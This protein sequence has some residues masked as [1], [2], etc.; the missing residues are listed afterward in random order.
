MTVEQ[1]MHVALVEDNPGDARLV[2]EMLR[3]AW[4]GSLTLAHYERL[5]D[6]LNKLSE[7]QPACILLDLSLPDAEGLDAV[8]RVTAI[9]PEVPV[10]V[11]TGRDDE[12]LALEAVQAGAQDYLLKGRVD[13]SLLSRTI[14]Y[15]IERKRA[16]VQLTQQAL[17][18][19]LTGLPNRLLFLDRLNLS[20]ARSGRRVPSSLAVLFLA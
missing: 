4:P 14:K 16:E 3:E 17:H 2:R 20:L 8:S 13:G 12:V 19:P 11:L 7:L 6:A 1:A 15:A 9:M 10:V 18:D 5:A